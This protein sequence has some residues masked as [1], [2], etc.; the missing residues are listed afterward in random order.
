MRKKKPLIVSVGGMAASGGYY[1]ASTGDT[2]FAEPG[3]LVGSIG[4][5]GGK[6]GFGPALERWGIHSGTFPAKVGDEKAKIRAAAES[7]L[8]AWDDATKERILQSMTAIYDLFLSRL[9]EGRKKPRSAIEPHAEGRIF[10]G[11]EGKNR[12]LVDELG[13][14]GAALTKAREAAKLPADAPAELYEEAPKLLEALGAGGDDEDDTKDDVSL[15]ISALDDAA[16]SKKLDALPAP[17]AALARGTMPLARERVILTLP[18]P[19]NRH[20]ALKKVAKT[21]PRL[22]AV[23]KTVPRLRAVAKT[24]PRLRAV[25]KTVPRLRAVAKTV[26]RLRAVA[27]TVPRLRAA[28]PSFP[29]VVPEPANGARYT[30]VR[31]AA[32]AEAR[33][34]RRGRGGDAKVHRLYA[35]ASREDL[36]EP[37]RAAAWSALGRVFSRELRDPPSAIDA[38]RRSLALQWDVVVAEELALLLSSIG[39]VGEAARLARSGIGRIENEEI[40]ATLALRAGTWAARA[41][42]RDDALALFR[43]PSL[44]RVF[45]AVSLEAE[46]A[47]LVALA[48]DGEVPGDGDAERSSRVSTSTA[49]DAWLRAAQLR[50]TVAERASAV[51]DLRRAVEALPDHADAVDALVARYE[52]DGQAAWCDEILRRAGAFGHSARHR[53]W[54]RRRAERALARGDLPLALHTVLEAELDG[55]DDEGRADVADRVFA[56]AGLGRLVALR[57]E[58]IQTLAT[59]CAV[60]ALLEDLHHEPERAIF[61]LG[62]ALRLAPDADEPRERLLAFADQPHL[63]RRASGNG[64]AIEALG[65]AP[66]LAETLA[67]AAE[68]R[69]MPVLAAWARLRGDGGN[70]V[71]ERATIDAARARLATSKQKMRSGGN[72]E[73]AEGFR[74]YFKL[75]A[76][77]PVRDAEF[78]EALVDGATLGLLTGDLVDLALETAEVTQ[79][80]PLVDALATTRALP[81]DRVALLR[82]EI[83]FAQR[84]PYAAALAAEADRLLT[85]PGSAA[86]FHAATSFAPHAPDDRVRRARALLRSAE[87][88]L[89]DVRAVLVAQAH[90]LAATVG[91]AR[92]LA[93]ELA[94][95]LLVRPPPAQLPRTTDLLDAV[96]REL[97]ARGPTVGTYDAL[98]NARE[99]SGDFAGALA[100]AQRAATLRP[101]DLPRAARVLDLASVNGDAE[102]VADALDWLATQPLLQEALAT[103]VATALVRVSDRDARAG[104]TLGA[105]VV[106]LLSA[107]SFALRQQLLQIAAKASDEALAILVLEAWIGLRGQAARPRKATDVVADRGANGFAKSGIADDHGERLGTLW[108]ALAERRSRRGDTLGR[109]EFGRRRAPAPPRGAPPLRPRGRGWPAPLVPPPSA[110][111]PLVGCCG[112]P[113]RGDPHLARSGPPPWRARLPNA[114][115]RPDRPCRLGARDVAAGATRRNGGRFSRKSSALYRE[116]PRRCHRRAPRRSVLPRRT[117]QRHRPEADGRPRN[118]GNGRLKRRRDERPLRQR[119]SRRPRSLRRPRSPPPRIPVFARRGDGRLA[120]KHAAA[121]FRAVPS[122]HGTLPALLRAAALAVDTTPAL[123]ALAD[124]AEAEHDGGAKG[125]WLLRAARLAAKGRGTDGLALEYGLRAIHAAPQ[126]RVVGILARLVRKYVADHP[127]DS[128]FVEGRL[129]KSFDALCRHAEGPDGARV[130]LGFVELDASAFRGALAWEGVLAALACDGDVDEYALLVPAARSLARAPGAEAGFFNALSLEGQ[131]LSNVGTAARRFLAAVAEERGARDARAFLLIKVAKSELEDD[132]IR[133]AVTAVRNA[134]AAASEALRKAFPAAR[135][136]PFLTARP[137][138]RAAALTPV[139]PLPAVPLPEFEKLAAPSSLDPTPG[140]EGLCDAARGT[141]DPEAGTVRL[142]GPRLPRRRVGRSPAA[143][144]HWRP[145]GSDPRCRGGGVARDGAPT[146]TVAAES[147]FEAAE[148]ELPLLGEVA[149]SVRE[150]ET[151]AHIPEKTARPSGRCKRPQERAED[152][153]LGS[154]AAP[155]SLPRPAAL[156]SQPPVR[157]ADEWVQTARDAENAGDLGRALDAAVVAAETSPERGDLWELVAEFSEAIGDSDTRIAARIRAV[158]C[159]GRGGRA[160]TSA[161]TQTRRD[162]ELE[163]ARAYAEN[164]KKDEARRLWT[165]LFEENPTDPL[166]SGA[167]QAQYVDEGRYDALASHLGQRITGLVA[168]PDRDE[169]EVRALRMRRAAVLDE[170]L[171]AYALAAEELLRVLDEHLRYEPALRYLAD[172]EEKRGRFAESASLWRRILEQEGD[173]PERS[174]RVRLAALLHRLGRGDEALAQ[175]DAT[176]EDDAP[177]SVRSTGLRIEILRARE[178]FGELGDALEAYAEFGDDASSVRADLLVEASQAAARVGNMYLALKRARRG[179]DLCPEAPGPQL[180]ARGLE[181]RLRGIGTPDE[182]RDTAIRLRGIRGIEDANDEALRAFLLAESLDGIEG[183]NA[184]LRALV[185]TKQRIGLLPLVALGLAERYVSRWTFQE[186]LPCFRVALGG[187]LLGLRRRGAVA[188]SAADAAMRRPPKDRPAG[189]PARDLVRARAVLRA[190]A[191]TAVGDEKAEA[192]GQL[193]R[194]LL[195]SS[196][197]KNREE[198]VVVLGEALESANPH[199]A[200]AATLRQEWADA[201]TPQEPMTVFEVDA[202]ADEAEPIAAGSTDEHFGRP[203]PTSEDSGNGEPLRFEIPLDARSSDA[204]RP[205]TDPHSP[206]GSLTPAP[207]LVTLPDGSTLLRSALSNAL[208]D[209]LTDVTTRVAVSLAGVLPDDIESLVATARILAAE[210]RLV[211]AVPSLE[212]AVRSGSPEA[213]DLLAQFWGGRPDGKREQLKVLRSAAELAPATCVPGPRA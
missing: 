107:R 19:T 11:R 202:G 190:V 151:T 126:P 56:A 131:P 166:P 119:R 93:A 191:S 180:Y 61:A 185:D 172:L 213:A 179:A 153:S 198:G 73:R 83:A 210:G 135:L 98:A 35:R 102:R 199:S 165:R 201:T 178:A 108:L 130:L 173:R 96:E 147:R 106:G 200:L 77:L 146:S 71:F 26:P 206:R 80:R 16:I 50:E 52:Q 204:L 9:E 105:R 51:E 111:L 75:A 78:A 14:L 29:N 128:E 163:L 33:P 186:A 164:G 34:L 36:P 48:A 144:G 58:R 24:V 177:P 1:L 47:A 74:E 194:A 148:M 142:D 156:P 110:G 209:V 188:L 79:D 120:M 136:E 64:C 65:R 114:R 46:A 89:V 67:S 25:A 94:D 84:D 141:G 124:A 170:H 88:A 6:I 121:A 91:T 97:S 103:H 95:Q 171:S 192:L 90:A 150:P 13:G 32:E 134:S 183:G 41:G 189:D 140:D 118:R 193:A 149:Y 101:G 4:V 168:R 117:G 175:L 70:L 60:A 195:S 129:R 159:A 116:C 20:R 63:R 162:A 39:D 23:A 174:T 3:S 109:G 139:E 12:G 31:P 127:S 182:A 85:S 158:A 167:L 8:V 169:L 208:P 152:P 87:L 62:R 54:L 137:D 15:A 76:E 37:D 112:R 197:E 59:Q 81:A 92:E 125:A 43:D 196:A 49:V 181:Y 57:R 10:S 42:D 45:P 184:G 211:E 55:T 132:D 207:P 212:G 145:P 203:S 123:D 22:R 104:A 154:F 68:T 38:F 17:F 72:S 28:T 155:A 2:I 53:E 18:A 86:L 99:M 21:V 27:K 113:R 66:E 187:D 160:G 122:E 82:A 7:P 176:L 138:A 100:A 69:G 30:P 205:V 161:Q 115:R 44:Q 5:V 157:N 143:D 40:R 133:L